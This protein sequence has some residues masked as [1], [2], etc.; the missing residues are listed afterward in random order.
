MI[1]EKE[2]VVVYYIILVNLLYILAQVYGKMIN[3][4]VMRKKHLKM[5]VFLK[6]ILKKKINLFR[7]IIT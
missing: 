1:E 7:N 6:E 2:M 3:Y 5:V 4:L